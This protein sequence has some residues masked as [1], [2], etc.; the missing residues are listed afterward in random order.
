MPKERI[1]GVTDRRYS[2][3]TGLRLVS[4]RE[5]NVSR[6]ASKTWI[7]GVHK[8]HAAGDHGT[9]AIERPACCLDSIDRH[10]RLRCIDVPKD[11]SVDSRKS[12]KVSIHRSR[13]HDPGQHRDCGR[14]CGAA[15]Y[16]R[17]IT[18]F[19]GYEPDL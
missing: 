11:L 1:V 5:Q 17:R 7:P 15:A 19:S 12:A 3:T 2:K 18:W 6:H 9:G 16:P 13:E 4:K 14:L 8:D 10:E